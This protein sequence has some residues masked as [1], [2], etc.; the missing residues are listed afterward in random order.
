MI[1]AGE[2]A[3][4]RARLM[5]LGCLP[6]VPGQVTLR[7]VL[8]RILAFLWPLEARSVGS[9]T[10]ELV[11]LCGQGRVRLTPTYQSQPQPIALPSG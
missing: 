2:D 4:L 9:E 7:P 1:E 10:P 6:V 5:R 11:M 8:N 3:F